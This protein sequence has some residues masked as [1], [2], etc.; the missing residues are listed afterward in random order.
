[1]SIGW[2]LHIDGAVIQRCIHQ[3]SALDE[4]DFLLGE[5]DMKRDWV[6][7]TEKAPQRAHRAVWNK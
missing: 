4:L 2:P 7:V 3:D 1:M 6:E 5:Y